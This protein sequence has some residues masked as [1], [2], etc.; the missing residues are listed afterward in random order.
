MELN[1]DNY[2]SELVN[3][4]R[5]LLLFYK[6]LCPHCLNMKKVIAKFVSQNEA[7][8]NYQIDSEE[9]PKAM[10]NLRV[11]RVPTILF[12]KL[13]KIAFRKE[14]LINVR[15]LRDRFQKVCS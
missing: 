13:G 14:G 15:E 1:N 2:A 12:L 5:G 7:V 9:C 6:K 11:E 4:S 8:D 10:Q 3:T